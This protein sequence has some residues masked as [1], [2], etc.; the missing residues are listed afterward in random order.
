[1]RFVALHRCIMLTYLSY[2]S[3]LLYV[4]YRK[5]HQEYIHR[6]V[7]RFGA[8]VRVHVFIALLLLL[9]LLASDAM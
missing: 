3:L 7:Q 4:L 1:M 9:L 6:Y 8:F 5:Q 2:L